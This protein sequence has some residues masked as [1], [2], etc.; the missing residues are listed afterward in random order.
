LSSVQTLSVRAPRI[1]SDRA[2]TGQGVTVAVLDSGIQPSS[3]LPNALLGIDLVTNSPTLGDAGGHGSHVAG[4]IAGT[5]AM[6]NGVYKGVSPDAR[7]I[8]VKVADDSGTATYSSVIK[9]IQWVV[10]NRRTYNIRVMNLSLGA[11][12]IGTYKNDPLAAAVEMAWFSGI[13]VVSSAGNQSA[14]NVPAND[15][16]VI[17]VGALDQNE[18]ASRTDD[19][20]ALWSARGPTSYDGLAKPDLVA[21]GRRVISLRVPGSYL[22][23]RQPSQAVGSSYFRLSG[24]S[25]AAPVVSGV[26]A[27]VLAANP[28]LTPNQ[29]KYVL[30]ESAHPVVGF[31]ANDQGAGQVDALEAIDLAR[32]GILSHLANRGQRPSD[33]FAHSVYTLA[34]GAPIV[35]RDP[36]YLGR[37]WSTWNW[38]TGV[39]DSATWENLAWE[40]I[41][42]ERADWTSVTWESLSGWQGNTWVG[43]NDGA[44]DA[45]A[46]AGWSDG[47]L[48]T[49]RAL[50]GATAAAAPLD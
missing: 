6:S 17:A 19:Q 22:D 2:N 21:G 30:A 14:I 9:G 39:W 5:G 29:V 8:S 12:A 45:F 36:R 1:W 42:W 3:D 18:T 50:E 31:A 24:T 49:L 32:Q 26:A 27:L 10:A 16:Y 35:W 48:D 20:V 43:W 15:P 13:V 33:L 11:T 25:M 37:D 40:Q 23:R 46:S 44:L 28:G 38:Q 4:I 7:L 47:A 41:A 34:Q